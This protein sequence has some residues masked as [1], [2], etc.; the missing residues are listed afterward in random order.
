MTHFL[1]STV[2]EGVWVCVGAL[3]FDPEV[4]AIPPETAQTKI[5]VIFLKA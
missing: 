4:T 5:L 2:A 1:T 3:T